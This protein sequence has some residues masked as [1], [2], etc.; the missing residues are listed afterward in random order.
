MPVDV[1]EP[2]EHLGDAGQEIVIQLLQ[3]INDKC[4]VVEISEE[5]SNTKV[6]QCCIVLPAR[7]LCACWRW[8]CTW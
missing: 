1:L 7:G 4:I 3:V 5:S 8:T 6:L 2:P